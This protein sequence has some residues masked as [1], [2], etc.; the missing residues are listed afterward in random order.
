M[1]WASARSLQPNKDLKR[2]ALMAGGS[3]WPVIRSRS[4]N[5]HRRHGDT[6]NDRGFSRQVAVGGRASLA[7]VIDIH[8]RRGARGGLGQSIGS[9][10]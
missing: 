3:D 10:G 1:R 8:H 6:E 9:I 4:G 5:E 7:T 2:P